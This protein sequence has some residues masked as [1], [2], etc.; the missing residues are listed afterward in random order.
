MGEFNNVN[1]T[2]KANVYFNGGVTSRTISFENCDSK[3]LGMM[4]PGEYV[5][6]T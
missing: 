3:T 4:Q 2:K 6:N 1:I 5:F